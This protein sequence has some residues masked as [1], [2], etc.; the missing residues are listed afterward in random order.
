MLQ[1]TKQVML[2]FTVEIHMLQVL[3]LQQELCPTLTAFWDLLTEGLSFK[4]TWDVATQYLIGEVVEYSTNSYR[5]I[6]DD[7]VES[8]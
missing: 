8:T 6:Q 1:H 4:G 5:A 2:L 3:I 7:T